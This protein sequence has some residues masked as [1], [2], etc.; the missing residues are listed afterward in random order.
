M[1]HCYD[2]SGTF[3]FLHNS[4]S[5]F[6]SL[7]LFFS[8]TSIFTTRFLLTHFKQNN[9]LVAFTL[10][11]KNARRIQHSDCLGKKHILSFLKLD[12]IS[13][14]NNR[15]NIFFIMKKQRTLIIWNFQLEQKTNKKFFLPK[16]KIKR[17]FR[18]DAFSVHKWRQA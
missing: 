6:F 1:R 17:Q 3:N 18:F 9:C 5:H 16:I 11:G 13:K 10:F 7:F 15:A 14:W 4:F 8:L 12:L 2:R